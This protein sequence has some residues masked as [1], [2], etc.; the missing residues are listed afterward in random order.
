VGSRTA[1]G[2]STWSAC[3]W[4]RVPS[5]TFVVRHLTQVDLEESEDDLVEEWW[6]VS[7]QETSSCVSAP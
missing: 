1:K 3:I 7:M 6:T 4:N 5:S 2:I